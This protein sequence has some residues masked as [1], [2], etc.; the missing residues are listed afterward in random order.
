[1]GR[2]GREVSAV[3]TRS[4]LCVPLCL[5][6]K[7]IEQS[8]VVELVNPMHSHTFANL[9]NQPVRALGVTVPAGLEGVFAELVEY[10]SSP[11][12]PPDPERIVRWVIG[13]AYAAWGPLGPA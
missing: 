2:A 9:E 13:M 12:G 5:P 3:G 8:H 11:H 1:M 4:N 6:R 10:F 7:D